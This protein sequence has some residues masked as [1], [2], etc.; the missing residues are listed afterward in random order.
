MRNNRK[1]EY[2]NMIDSNH[3]HRYCGD[4]VY[5]INNNTKCG[6]VANITS[7]NV[8]ANSCKVYLKRIG[9]DIESVN[10]KGMPWKE[11]M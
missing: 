10:F 4:C 3:F 1:I 2:L 8:L 11:D 7:A 5:F 9:A 6:G